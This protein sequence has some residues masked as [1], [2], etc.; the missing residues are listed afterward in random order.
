MVGS[1]KKTTPWDGFEFT[2]KLVFGSD[3]GTGFRH[4]GPGRVEQAFM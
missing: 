4:A 3:Q 2:A 1:N